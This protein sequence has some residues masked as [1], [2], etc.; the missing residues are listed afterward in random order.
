MSLASRAAASASSQR[1]LSMHAHWSTD[2]TAPL[3]PRMP[4]ARSCRSPARSTRT[5]TSVSSRI[6]AAPPTLP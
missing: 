5:A 3:A 2:S 1:P 6:H 4:G